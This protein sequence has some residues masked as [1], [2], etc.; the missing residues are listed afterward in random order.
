MSEMRYFEDETKKKPK[1]M[2]IL[3]NLKCVS[4][5]EDHKAK[6]KYG[7]LLY[8]MK[9]QFIT[10]R[11][12][13]L[14]CLTEKERDL[15]FDKIC[16]RNKELLHPLPAVMPKSTTS[17]SPSASKSQSKQSEPV[18]APA[19]IAPTSK[20]SKQ[21]RKTTT[22]AASTSTSTATP[23]CSTSLKRTKSS[24]SLS[25]VTGDGSKKRRNK[26]KP[27]PSPLLKT[28][29][30]EEPLDTETA[31]GQTNEAELDK[32]TNTDTNKGHTKSASR[33]LHFPAPSFGGS[34][35]SHTCNP[36]LLRNPKNQSPAVSKMTRSR[37]AFSAATTP[38]SMKY[39]FA[40]PLRSPPPAPPRL[41]K[42]DSNGSSNGTILSMPPSAMTSPTMSAVPTY[43]TSASDHGTEIGDNNSVGTG[44]SGMTALLY[45]DHDRDLINDLR[46]EVCTLREE[47]L[48]LKIKTAM[49]LSQPP[50]THLDA[51]DIDENDVDDALLD[52]DQ[53]MLLDKNW[54]NWT[55]LEIVEW[56]C[57]LEFGRYTKYK[58]VLFV[59][60][61]HRNVNGKYL[62]QIDKADLSTFFGITD[63]G[64]ICDLFK[65]IQILTANINAV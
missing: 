22:S 8:L 20:N 36:L 17:S 41:A 40:N 64:D 5:S 50:P 7:Q 42:F 35:F 33:P 6:K 47:I 30:S 53:Y 43:Y 4:K 28:I 59:N 14:A 19:P 49:K 23:S 13:V 24:K 63:Y 58:V 32:D 48:S 11:V 65:Q 44:V 3:S 39:E 27:A 38:K 56:I 46:A 55:H 12:I 18:P 52:S 60:M 16:G 61:R 1:G 26:E 9:L 57:S 2:V 51:A 62:N 25:R 15:W 37:S 34:N 29:Q 54:P 21:R 10:Q 45:T 31:N